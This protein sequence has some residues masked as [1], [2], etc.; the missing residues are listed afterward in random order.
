MWTHKINVF[1]GIV[2]WHKT[3]YTENANEFV[4][5]KQ[6]DTALFCLLEIKQYTLSCCSIRLLFLL[7]EVWSLLME[8]NRID[9]DISVKCQDVS[10]LYHPPLL[11]RNWSD[12]HQTR[13]RDMESGPEKLSSPP[14]QIMKNNERQ[15]TILV[16]REPRAGNLGK[17]NISKYCF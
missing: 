17:I 6:T 2:K 13:P 16:S 5:R 9:I 1:F 8:K 12:T 15:P 10:L 4:C 3:N 7:Y 11:I 14:G